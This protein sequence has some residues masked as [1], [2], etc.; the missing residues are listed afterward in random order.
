MTSSRGKSKKPSDVNSTA[1][2]PSP[3]VFFLDRSLGKKIIA[4]AL[5]QAG[6]DVQ[7]HDDYFPPDT[8]DEEWLTTAGQRGWIVLTKDRRI[9]YRTPERTALL[10][11]DV[12]AFVL[13]AGNLQGVEMAAIFIKALS[14]MRRFVADAPPP[15]IATVTRSGKVSILVH[16]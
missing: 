9:R 10:R 15:F 6:V 8:R 1:T 2:L 11:A 16:R 13:T 7:I 5:R 12:R 4:E 14:S 3:L